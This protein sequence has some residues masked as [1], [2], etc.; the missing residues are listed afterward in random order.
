MID[1]HLHTTAS[2]G[3]SSPSD[4]VRE[5]HRAGLTTIAVTDHDTTAGLADVAA[6]AQAHGLDTVSGI[7]ITAVHRG[8]DVHVLGYFFDAASG[9]LSTFL[10]RQR[11]DR[12][13][14]VLAMLDRLD[15]LGLAVDRTAVM[16]RAAGAGGRA[17]GRPMLADALVRAG[18]V[19][20]ISEAFDRFLGEGRTA[21]IE[22]DGAPPQR[23]LA[24]IAGAGGLSSLAHPGKL[25]RD[26]LIP[27]LVD[28][29]LSAIEVHHPDHDA[30]DVGRYRQMAAGLGLLV[31]GGSDYHGP[32]S[33]RTS[34]LGQVT[35]PRGDFVRLAERVAAP[36]GRA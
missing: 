6:A 19:R 16:E 22:R 27:E 32:G 18:H 12:R 24:L 9:D 14:R 1:L 33:G 20:S 7:E 35:L 11:E 36:G 4:L 3:R 15:T 21:Y 26:D 13:R 31:T 34:G 8:R 30:I 10:V 25:R 28:A 2:D 5:A 23:V 29:G 17:I